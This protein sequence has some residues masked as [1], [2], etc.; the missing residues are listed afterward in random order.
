MKKFVAALAVAGMMLAPTAVQADT[1]S[2]NF[3]GFDLGSPNNQ[4]GWEFT[5]PY[6]V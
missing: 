5:G 1:K 2:E 4:G 3:E 6:D